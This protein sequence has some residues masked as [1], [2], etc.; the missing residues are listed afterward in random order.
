MTQ[1]FDQIQMDRESL[2]GGLKQVLDEATDPWGVKVTRVEITG[3]LLILATCCG[4][5]FNLPF[6]QLLLS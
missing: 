2:A 6:L 3:A 4:K 5:R 1:T